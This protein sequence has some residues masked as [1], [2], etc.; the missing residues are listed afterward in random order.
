[1]CYLESN[2]HQHTITY[3]STLWRV[4]FAGWQATLWNWYVRLLKY[5]TLCYALW[6]IHMTMKSRI[7]Y[8][9]AVHC[10]VKLRTFFSNSQKRCLKCIKRYTGYGEEHI[11]ECAYTLSVSME[12]IYVV[13]MSSLCRHTKYLCWHATCFVVHA[14]LILKSYAMST[15]WHTCHIYLVCWHK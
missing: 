5:A 15:Y 6:L 1:M 4:I 12:Y 14:E 9:N 10:H 13:Y 3:H 11:K 2:V 7:A 8:P